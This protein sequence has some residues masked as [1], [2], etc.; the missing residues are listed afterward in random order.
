[1]ATPSPG[2]RNRTE[3]SWRN[4]GHRATGP[5]PNIQTEASRVRVAT[6]QNSHRTRGNASGRQE[7]LLVGPRQTP[8]SWEVFQWTFTC[9]G[10][11]IRVCVSVRILS[12]LYVWIL[13]SV[14][15]LWVLSLVCVEFVFGVRVWILCWVSVRVGSVRTQLWK[16]TAFHPEKLAAMLFVRTTKNCDNVVCVSEQGGECVCVQGVWCVSVQGARVSVV[17]TQT[18]LA[19]GLSILQSLLDF[20]I[21]RAGELRP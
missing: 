6:Y 4:G 2:R 21:F 11:E 1:M 13:S 10:F 9:L 3:T 7:Q 15:V 12:F 8:G 16:R 14:C 17:R 5:F 19:H 18:V 20:F